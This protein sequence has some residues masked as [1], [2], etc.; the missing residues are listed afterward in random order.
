MHERKLIKFMTKKIINRSLRK[1]KKKRKRN[2]KKKINDDNDIIDSNVLTTIQLIDDISNEKIVV[3]EL[4]I[5][6][7]FQSIRD[8]KTALINFWFYQNSRDI[9]RHSQSND[10][11]LQILMKAQ[12]TSQH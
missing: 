2:Q 3:V 5:T 4:S 8:Y 7:K 1:Q 6:L 12:K 11:F 10:V 9:N